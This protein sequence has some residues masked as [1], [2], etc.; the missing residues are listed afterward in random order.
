MCAATVRGITV[1]FTV[2]NRGR[3]EATTCLGLGRAGLA[4]ENV[5]IGDRILCRCRCPVLF[6]RRG[7]LQTNQCFEEECWEWDQIQMLSP[8]SGMFGQV[9]W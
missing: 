1:L 6:R 5:L 4:L 2:A 8:I 3:K 9:L 7:R